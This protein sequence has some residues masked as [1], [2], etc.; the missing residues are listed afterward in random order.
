MSKVSSNGGEIP[1]SLS[2]LF[3]TPRDVCQ[4][5]QQ[6]VYQVEK[7][8]PVN[9]VV[10]HKQCFRCSVCGQVLS[11]KTYFTNHANGKDKEIYCKKCKPET[12]MAG[13]DS[14]AL[15]IRAFTNVPTVNFGR[16]ND[17]IRGGAAPRIGI[18]ASHIMNPLM[19][20]KQ[21]G[22]K[23]KQSLYKHNFPAYVVCT[24]VISYTNHC[25]ILKYCCLLVRFVKLEL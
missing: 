3:N 22:H 7:V 6:R 20:Q 1:K 21:F 24:P 25:L 13:Y 18:D 15:G 14:N 9:E 19:Q 5:C 17:Q 2:N 11:L 12:T 16:H 8:G 10:F 23:Y 4:R